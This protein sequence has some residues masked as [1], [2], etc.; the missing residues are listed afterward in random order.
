MLSEDTIEKGY[1]L[2]CVATPLSDVK[3]DCIAEVRE[4]PA[5]LHGSGIGCVKAFHGDGHCFVPFSV[6]PTPQLPF[7]PARPLHSHPSPWPAAE[8]S[9]HCFRWC[10]S[11]QSVLPLS[12]ISSLTVIANLCEFELSPLVW[13]GGSLLH[14]LRNSWAITTRIDA[15]SLSELFSAWMLIDTAFFRFTGGSSCCAD[16]GNIMWIAPDGSR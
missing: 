11:S 3:I 4:R 9:T 15:R 6:V 5:V 8:S 12:H 7:A 13:T 16:G 2:M 10:R 1:M 14:W